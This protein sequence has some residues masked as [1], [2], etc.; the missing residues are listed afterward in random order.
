MNSSFIFKCQIDEYVAKGMGPEEA[1]YAALRSLGGV[2]QFKQECRDMRS[3][4]FIEHIQQDLRFGFR[5]LVRSPGF[6]LLAILCLTVGIGANA[7]VFSW[8]EGVLFRPYPRVAHQERLLVL[9]G[10]ARGTPGFDEVSW[11]DFL[12]FQKNC[13]L[14]DAVHRREDRRHHAQHW[15]SGR[16]HHRQ[17]C[18]GE[19]FRRDGSPSS[20]GARF[21]ARRRLGTQRPSR[22]GD[23]LPTLARPLSR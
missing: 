23:Q 20:A 7:A 12:D 1:R 16:A 19:L 18:V 17:H 2:E 21:R 9:A 14:V 11:P 15:R 6:S 5:M 13:T 8:I 4:S 10:T 22:R 3:V